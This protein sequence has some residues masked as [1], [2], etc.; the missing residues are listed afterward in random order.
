MSDYL[1]LGVPC[2][3]KAIMVS[4]WAK[5]GEPFQCSRCGASVTFTKSHQLELYVPRPPSRTFL[6][7][8]LGR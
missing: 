4:V 2:C 1:I 5:V 6:Q 7:W 3:G 8:L